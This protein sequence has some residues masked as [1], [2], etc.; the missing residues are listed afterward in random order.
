M[1]ILKTFLI[2]ITV[3]LLCSGVTLGY[4]YQKGFFADPQVA[5]RELEKQEI[6]ASVVS[7]HQAAAAGNL[8]VLKTLARAQVDFSQADDHGRT[9]LHHTIAGSHLDALPLLREQGYDLDAR[10]QAG[11]TPLSLLLDRSLHELASQLIAEGASPDFTLPSGELALPGYHQA[12][13]DNDVAFLLQH[14]ANP[15]SPALDGQSPLALALQDGQGELA[16]QLLEKGANP[17]GLIFGEP[18]LVALLNEYQN[19][20]LDIPITTRVIGTLLISGA[21]PEQPGSKGERPLQIAL[22]N[23]FRPTLELLLPRIKNVDDCLWLAIDNNNVA[24]IENLLAKGAPVEEVGPDGDTPL[25]HAL[26]HGKADLVTSLLSADAN[27]NQ[28]GKEGQRA[29]FVALACKQEA[30]T[31]ALLKHS[32]GPDLSV[33]MES[34]VSEEYRDLFARKGLFDWYCRNETGLNPLMAAVMLRSLPLA[35]RLLELEMDRFAGTTK[36]VYAI[37]MAAAN[38]DV[39]MQQ[40]LIGV[41]Y[42]DEDQERNFVIDLSEQKVTYY[43]NGEVAKTSRISSGMRGFRTQTGNFV[44]TDKTRHKKSNIYD[45]APMP[46]FQRFSC[47]AIGFHEGNTYSRFASHGCIRLPRST[48]QYFWGQTKIGD[49]VTIQD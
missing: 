39:K 19:W 1:R 47:K 6:P 13:R 26:R 34:P 10:D 31:L 5:L 14:G 46:Y 15:D 7:V 18:A 42:R 36:G 2:L 40:L 28:F 44:I 8:P 32:N 4:L 33:V 25:I 9:A 22:K 11:N 16:C 12:K 41:S 37:Q 24:A 45:A 49:R 30:A 35:E 29:I 38:G 21:D 20:K 27:P 23:D 3:L 43:K 48:A 17:K